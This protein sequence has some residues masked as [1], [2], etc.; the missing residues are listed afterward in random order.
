MGILPEYFEK[1][2]LG[3]I[4]FLIDYIDFLYIYRGLLFR[5]EILFLIED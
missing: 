3:G 1:F 5:S 2:P 4:L